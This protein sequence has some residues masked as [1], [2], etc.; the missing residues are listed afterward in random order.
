MLTIRSKTLKIQNN[1]KPPEL[2]LKIFLD[3][4][5]FI[6]EVS[7]GLMHRKLKTFKSQESANNFFDE[8][9]QNLIKN[10]DL[11]V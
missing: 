1:T 9:Y 8:Y 6:V 10:P 3:D 4:S 11:E 7:D 2:F 5:G